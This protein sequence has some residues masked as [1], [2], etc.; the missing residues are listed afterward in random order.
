M[1]VIGITANISPADDSRRT[2]SKGT[3]LQLIQESYCQW[4]NLGGG[5]P[6]IIPILDDLNKATDIM[7]K[8]DGLLVTGGVDVDPSLYHEANS[9]S[10]G[11]DLV[12]DKFEI[13]L[14]Q[15]ARA[16]AKAVLGICRGA[17]VLNVA[18]GGSLYQDIPSSFENPLQHHDWEGGKD[19]F[20]TVLFTRPSPLSNLFESSEIQ[21]NSSHNQSVSQTGKGLE[22]LAA[23]RDGV[24]EAI[25]C[26]ADRFT[27]GLQWHPERMQEDPN[28]KAIA[29]WFVSFAV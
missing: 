8:L 26:P 27:F 15:A 17:Q 4:V 1:P 28:Q 11:C 6:V 3:K 22:I 29:R 9:K 24:V 20:H 19:A 12:R 10:M 21:V 14:V 25:T 2:F 7:S 13:A 5:T 23:A 16:E 18:F